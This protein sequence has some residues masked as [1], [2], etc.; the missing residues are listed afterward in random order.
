MERRGSA[1]RPAKKSETLE[2][3]LPHA[4]KSAFAARC[5][6]QGVTV[7][8]AVRRFI[9]DQL[10]APRD[11]DLRWRPLAAAAA[12]GLALGAL[13]APS[14]AQSVR[15]DRAAFDRL[16]ADRDGAISFEEFRAR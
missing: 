15:P 14:I 9:D 5:R 3:R 4:T 10:A 13:A 12:A 7:S 6:A 1:L 16:D 8:E 2:V 11:R